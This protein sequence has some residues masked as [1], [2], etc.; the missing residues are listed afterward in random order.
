[1]D[2]YPYLTTSTKDGQYAFGSRMTFRYLLAIGLLCILSIFNYVIAQKNIKY[3][4]TDAAVINLSGRQRML[5]QRIAML[6][7]R[8]VIS[9]DEA[10][11]ERL[12]SGLSS[13][14]KLMEDTHNLLIH[15]KPDA[16]YRF[17]L[18]E[19][20][21]AIYFAAPVNLDAK[22]HSYFEEAKALASTPDAGLTA[23]NSHLRNILVSSYADLI[24]GLDSAVKQYELESQIGV[25]RLQKIEF[26]LLVT[27]ISIL[28]IIALFIFRPMAYRIQRNIEALRKA[29]EFSDNL[30]KTIP[31][32]MDI[33]D[34]EG[35][36]VYLNDKLRAL[37]GEDAIGRK[38]YS[39]YKDNQSPCD[40]CPLKKSIDVGKTESLEVGGVFG[41]RVFR[42]SHSGMVYQGRKSVLE[43]FEDITDEK[44]AEEKLKEAIS[45]KS[46][47]IS[48]V[49]HELRTPLTAIR[50]GIAIV[51]DGS[52]GSINVEQ[53]EFLAIA[54][55]NVDRLSRFINGVLDY[56]RLE[57]GRMEFEM[58]EADINEVVKDVQ[59]VMATLAKNKGLEFN[60][61]LQEGL[62]MVTFDRDKIT[63]VLLN[64]VN[65]AIKFTEKGYIKIVTSKS[66]SE[67]AVCVWVQDTGTGIKKEDAKELFQSFSQLAKG[68][69][70]KSGSTGLGLAISEKIIAQHGGR[71]WFESAYGRGS[72][73][74]FT[75]PMK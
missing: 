19:A 69:D 43:I 30:L 12:R 57:A 13:T 46:N 61:E 51:L 16:N 67:D 52:A 17:P 10:E 25:S 2:D 32:G 27:D 48:M 18:S 59:E 7:L 6:S 28:L 33:V 42:I 37:F 55:K 63:Q 35:N 65:N 36:I 15:G 53:K 64:L 40:N 29:N 22:L 68:G 62:P 8:L 71:I 34:E 54:A 3:R 26:Y 39:V 4:E 5:S 73:F 49:S 58:N 47:F 72:T 75:L 31:F 14:V 44:Q 74:Y 24:N 9:T 66:E 70:R 38:C 1:M 45:I 50:E 21:K 41:G 11:L 23:D 60:V 56:Q 20:L